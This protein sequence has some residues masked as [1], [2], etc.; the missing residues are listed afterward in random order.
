MKIQ[1]N[2]LCDSLR[3]LAKTILN[4]N[5]GMLTGVI[6]ALAAP[7]AQGSV[8]QLHGHVPEVA[9]HLT[10]TGGLAATNELRLAICLPLR[11]QEALT[12]LLQRIYDPS[13]PDYRHY[14]S[15][16]QFAEQFGPTESDYQTTIAFAK[17]NGLAVTGT[18]PNRTLLDVSGAVRDIEQAFHVNLRLYQ[19]PT[20][21]RSFY[22][23][24]VE[25]SV[26]LAVPVLFIAGLENYDLPHPLFKRRPA[27]RR[28]PFAAFTGSGPGGNFM[29]SDFR[30][31][32]APGVTLT[33]AGQTVALFELDGYNSSDIT[34]YEATNGLANVTLT[35]VLLGGFAGLPVNGAEVEVCLDI[36]M[37]ISMA[38]GLS[39]VMVYEAPLTSAG[40]YDILNQIATDNQAKQI[41]SSWV[42][43]RV[44]TT[45]V[46][47]SIYQE[48][49]AQGQSFF[50]ASGDDDAYGA[51]IYQTAGNPYTTTVGGTTLTTTGPGGSFVSETVW[52]WGG[53]TGSGGGT[54]TTYSFPSYQVGLNMTNN[55][56]ST[57]YRNVPDVALTADDVYVRAGGEDNDDVGG[58][59][60][61]APLWAGFMALV[62]QQA[63][64]AGKST[65]GFINPAVYALAQ[66][67]SYANC[68]HDIVTGN[69]TN[70]VSPNLYYACPGYDLC[71]GWG[72]P[73]GQSLINALVNPE[74]LT[75]TPQAGFASSGGVGGPFTI[76]S[77]SLTLTNSGT[78]TLTWSMINTSLWLTASPSGGT[79]TPGGASAT[80][81]A[82]LNSVASNLL[83]GS[84]SA[85]LWFTNLNDNVGQ[86]RQFALSILSPPTITQQ[87]TNQSVLDGATAVFTVGS[88]GGLPLSYQWQANSNN[89]ADSTHIS[90][91]ATSTL[92]I[93]NISPA[94]AANYRVVVTNTAGTA[95]SSNALLI[96]LPGNVDHFTWN[97]VSATQ[98]FSVPFGV[99][100][101][102]RDPA[103]VI[104]TNFSGVVNI[105]GAGNGS[106][107]T[108]NLVIQTSGSI[109]VSVLGILNNLGFHYNFV[110]ANIFTGLNLSNYNTI[111]LGMD[112]GA[113]D[114]ASMAYLATVVN[115]GAKLIVLG[116]SAWA[117]YASGLN[118]FFIHIN[119]NNYNWTTV[120]GSP[121][122]SITAP[123]NPLAA[124]LPLNYNFSN[125]SAS[126]Y[127]AR[128]TDGSA[129]TV[130]TNGDGFACL[131]TKAI[132]AGGITM[133]INAPDDSYWSNPADSN[134]L[135]TVISNALQYNGAGGGSPIPVTP[136]VSG[137]FANGVW[138]G[139]VTVWQASSNVV[140]TANDGAGHAGSSNPLSVIYSNQPPLITLQPANQTLPVGVSATF[141]VSAVGSPPLSYYW[142]RNG[143]F[144]AGA[145][146]ATY[147]TNNVQL[148]DSGSQFS[149]VVSNAYGITNS[150]AAT[151]TVLAL[152][153]LITQQPASQTVNIG[154]TAS[155]SL[156]ATGSLP[157]S[158]LWSR[159]GTAIAGATNSSYATNNV[160]LTDTGS[161]FS[162]LVSNAYGTNNTQVATLTV[163]NVPTD[164]FTE[165][166]AA[167]ITNLAFN[168][169]TFT[170]NGS[171]NFYALCSQPA[172]TF[173]SDPTGGTSLTE[174]DDTYAQITLSGTNTVAI[175]NN[176]TNVLFVGSNGY[177]TMNAGDTSFSPT[178]AT[179]FALPRVSAVYRDLNPGAGGTVSWK[180]FSDRAAITYQA[181]PIFGSTTQTN[182]FQIEMF[183][184][185]RIRLT[186]LSLNT[187]TG[188][189][190]LSAGTGQPTNFV[191]SDYTTYTTC[192]PQP[193]LI[194]LQPANQTI[195]TGGS[196]SFGVSAFG[197]PPLN[198]FWQRNGLLIAGATNSAY[199]TNN[200]QLADS[201]S[202]FSCVVSNAYGITNSQAATLTVLALPPSI[203]QQP[204]SQTVSAGGA[205]SF[206]VTASGSLPLSYF[207][208]RNGTGIAG[209]TN[210][211]YTTN[212][213]QVTDSGSLFSCVVSNAYGTILSSNAMLTVLSGPV[214]LAGSYLYL[215]IQTN[216]V[217]LASNTG[218]KYNSA[219]T[220]G[221][222][223]VD[224]WE[225]GTPVYNWIVGVGGTN[226]LNGSAPVVG[227][228]A[229]L[230][231]SN[232][233][234]GAQQHAVIS[235]V[236]IPGL[237]FTRDISF[238]T[239]SKI[240]RLVDTLLNTSA[241]A[242]SNVVIFDTADPDQ[243]YAAPT[244]A[245]TSTLNDVVSVNLNNDM[246]IATGPSTGLS[247]GFGSDSGWQI[248]SAVGFNNLNAY[249]DLTVVDPNGAEADIDINL[250][251][252]YG[253]LAA[254]QSRSTVW[255]T[256]FGSSKLEVTN[257]FVSVSSNPPSILSQPANLTVPIGGNASF[258]VGAG[259]TTPLNYFWMRNG[260][261]I[262]GAT[263]ATYLTNNVQLTDSGSLFSC[264]VSNAY[265][266]ATSSNAMLTVVALPP[267]INQQ[268][269]NQTVRIG[270]TAT[271]TV[272][273]S[274]TP[275]L[276]YFW[277]C[278]GSPIPGAGASSYSVSNAQVN[279]SGSE[280]SCW[281]TNIAGSVTSSVAILKVDTTVANDQCSGAIVI[282]GLTYT[283]TQYTTNATS[284]GDP[285][286]DCVA[287]FGN[288]VWYLYTP[289]VNGQL[290]ADTFG[291]DFDTGLALYTGS[292]GALT[293]VACN[294]DTGGLQSQCI[295]PVVAGTTYYILAGGYSGYTGRLLIHLALTAPVTLDHFGWSP[296]SP[297]QA[298][299]APFSAVVIALS[300][301]NVTV[302]N[303]NGTVNLSG[304][305]GGG[306]GL[307]TNTILG[308]LVYADSGSGSYTLGYS[309]TPNTNLTV[310][311]VRSYSGSKVSIWTDAGA[312]LATQ[313]VA[314][315]PGTW[316][317][318]PLA[319]PLPLAAGSTYRVAFYSAAT[320]YYWRTD[321]T[322]TF[323]YGTINQSYEAAGDT[324]P[325]S[326]DTARW[327]LVD[328]RYTVG[329]GG[330]LNVTPT[331]SGTFTN[332]VWTGNLAVLQVATNAVLSASDGSGHVGSSN[333]FQV[334]P[335]LITQVSLLS[336][337]NIQITMGSLLGDVFRVQGS[338]NLLSWQ[339]VATVTNV[340]GTVQFTDPGVATNY[341]HRFYRL[342]M[343]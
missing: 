240:I 291:S 337:G 72:S 70:A 249:G 151:L 246:V 143:A 276:S 298:V 277:Q 260:G 329:S 214:F 197:T 305:T 302:T 194:T 92:I 258:T 233:S 84:Y 231:V 42:I 103:N 217:F 134:V 34:Y 66:T 251:Q 178:Y 313:A 196:V 29:G 114:Y 226:Y 212:N 106:G 118:D 104:A 81:T 243:D 46:P 78:N 79:L 124:G 3:A 236:V 57:A 266:V 215:P 11:N 211:S 157:M 126:Y 158:Y 245:T 108:S 300:P 15:P 209:A 321:G 22:A 87:P 253:T 338:T 61:A 294:D 128:V 90:G 234:S 296:I 254:G 304:S 322:N 39:Q 190:G 335:L 162:C 319:T 301:L 116:G 73:A 163:L 107:S 307:A 317:A 76:T 174:G 314:S 85:T 232:L 4:M 51:G 206:S 141:S 284:S 189:V 283:N 289:V 98:V 152:P 131:T 341:N 339:T 49:V 201:G 136:V 287:G 169:Y 293:E 168:T 199:T 19:H 62:N 13:S 177:L 154:G 53:G 336:H 142:A 30:N 122:F 161:Q 255:Y 262:P 64:A 6:L 18:H 265:G 54:N 288:G 156:V 203:S 111:I 238:A 202:Q 36:E 48:Y 88:S 52:Q 145:T 223:G 242:L 167:T 32:Y 210:S 65:V 89:L 171:A 159:N 343:P 149:C 27:N 250:A 12:N 278:N 101:T 331:V 310:T 222:S 21:A 213:V 299:N 340:T 26:D 230:T 192:G 23:P 241:T 270:A 8:Q 164:W 38:P 59:S 264:V 273:A 83:V 235:G 200:V 318:I 146:N 127:M 35:N 113:V 170:P 218:A 77:L 47:N 40:A 125:V 256:I 208:L 24:D 94:D 269:T 147:S 334:A 259:G 219:G 44:V 166:F 2:Q 165:L 25:P 295:L 109:T 271:F 316:L 155:F 173:P 303:F 138:T 110:Q 239:N 247:V 182:T 228:V 221:A 220:G 325:T 181:V 180:Q 286:P 97:T 229:S 275:P 333:P 179:H 132:G 148:A 261:L 282:S 115:A 69:N 55:G 204:A 327:W 133:F 193:P 16:G 306:G 224:Y 183:F 95:V 31:A 160:Q 244:N 121:E 144:I 175:Y 285:V 187:P 281:V 9:A 153:P 82:S 328:L 129:V 326:T 93:N 252:N 33:G 137:N 272:G 279:E 205:V 56:G 185:G 274:G 20:E 292:C 150:Q 102:A 207:W 227:G 67:P 311:E 130:A 99:G 60:C 320:N 290:E 75:I 68:F 176:R 96:A 135:R 280:Y 43:D 330:A 50:Q 184:D 80:V 112:G 71:T 119:T 342:V 172:V 324:F 312:L 45:P 216:G 323:A 86:S 117:P 37:A 139:N 332:G 257:L 58:T 17:A 195:P 74:A 91:S 140:L 123:G 105:T 248:P 225:P 186:Y 188:L 63:V 309:F 268:P 191:A 5:L 10:A 7:A 308:N 237:S 198:Y 14:L 263:N 41:S 120:A 100:I 315:V 297:F 1:M 28:K 267:S